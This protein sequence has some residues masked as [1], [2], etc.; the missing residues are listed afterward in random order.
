MLVGMVAPASA[1]QTDPVLSKIEKSG[2]LVVGTSA[3]YAPYEFHTTV[4]GKDKIVGFDISVANE[5][6][7]R[8]GVKLVIQEMSF[9]AL[10]G[11]VK[12]GKVD[13]VVAGMT[14]TPEREQEASFSEPYFV[15][16]N[17]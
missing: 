16:K 2:K 14:A 10:L 6:A 3:D 4:N 17:V 13:M 5:I 12:T 1:A 8:L 7:K 9:D 11:A 15:D